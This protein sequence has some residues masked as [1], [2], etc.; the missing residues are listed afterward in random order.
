MQKDE[1]LF[2]INLLVQLQ[3]Q[4]LMEILKSTEPYYIRCIKP[5]DL[6][7][8]AIFD[9]NNVMQQLRSGV[10]TIE[11]V[12]GFINLLSTMLVQSCKLV[13]V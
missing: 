7:Q 3:L 5:N 13:F 9:N 1:T 12:L 11:T 2:L 6:L 10:N 4:Q 8:P